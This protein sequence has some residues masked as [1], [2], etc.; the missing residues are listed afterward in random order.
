VDRYTVEVLPPYDDVPATVERFIKGITEYSTAYFGLNNR[1][2]TITYE[3]RRVD[4]E[5]LQFL[6][7]APTRRLVRK[8]RTQLVE[9]APG[10]RF[11]EGDTGLP[12]S[13]GDSIGGGMLTLGRSDWYPLR[14]D[15]DT[16]PINALARILHPDAMRDSRVIIQILARPVA[17]R[18]VSNRWW[19]RHAESDRDYLRKEKQKGI[20]RRRERPATPREKTQA[21]RI[22]HKVGAPRFKTGIRF[23]VIGAA[24]YTPSRVKELSAGFNI[25]ENPDTGQYFKTKTMRTLRKS[26]L[27]P[28][29]EAVRSQELRG[30]CLPFQL[31][32]EE[33]AA[34]FSIPSIQSPNISYA[35]P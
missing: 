1:S 23:L 7:S 14:T 3:I 34:L 11:K 8:I 31:G 22:D 24:N 29:A 21:D 10:T 28:F 25:F 4:P 19:T 6:F 26:R 17:R 9:N 32:V 13:E 5:R 12:V 16:P 35:Q 18:T 30:W 15:F 20:I 2:P 27:K 33:L